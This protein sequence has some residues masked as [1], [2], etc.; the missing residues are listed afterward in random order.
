MKRL[1]LTILLLLLCISIGLL[2]A[3][4]KKATTAKIGKIVWMTDYDQAL[5]RA[6]KEKKPLWLHFGENP[7]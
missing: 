6:K 3:P 4:K 7:G 5:I 2:A 1:T